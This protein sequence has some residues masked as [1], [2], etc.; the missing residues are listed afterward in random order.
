MGLL[1]SVIGSVT[2]SKGSSGPTSPLVKALLL[3]L[4]AKA[5]SS[6]MHRDSASTDAPGKTPQ[7]DDDPG[8]IKSGML[9]G[10]PS[11]DALLE[12]FKHG[13]HAD[14]F[15]SWVGS[16]ENQPIRPQELQQALGPEEVDN[17]QKETGLP[18]E[19]LLEGLSRYLPRV[20]DKL[21]PSG[22]LP[23]PEEQARW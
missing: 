4:A 12:R 14:K 9:K 18:R 3:L 11:L 23:T 5:A 20:V 10:L 21:T 8:T 6:Y 7:P 1:D 2:G 15:H 16:G 17:L 19:Q 13:S 22:R